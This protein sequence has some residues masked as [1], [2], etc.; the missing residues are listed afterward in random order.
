[1]S[2]SAVSLSA[3]I[4]EAD[5]GDAAAQVELLRRYF[6]G[7]GLP[8]DPGEALAWCRRVALKGS[9]TASFLRRIDYDQVAPEGR[10]DVLAWVRE[11]AR[12]GHEEIVEWFQEQAEAGLSSSLDWLRAA[13]GEDGDPALQFQIGECLCDLVEGKLTVYNEE[14]ELHTANVWLGKAQ[15]Q[16]N[17]E[18]QS[19]LGLMVAKSCQLLI[20]AAERGDRRAQAWLGEAYYRGKYGPHDFPQDFAKSL[21]WLRKSDANGC[22]DCTDLLDEFDYGKVAPQ[23]YPEILDW[24]AQAKQEGHS[25][26]VDWFLDE[27]ECGATSSLDWLRAAAGPG[28]NPEVQ[29]RLAQFWGQH[30]RTHGNA[31]EG[32]SGTERWFRKGAEE[33]HAEAQFRL[34]QVLPK[35]IPDDEDG[36]DNEEVLGWLCKAAGQGY[37]E[38]QYELG[39]YWFLDEKYQTNDRKKDCHYDWNGEGQDVGQATEWFRKAADQG[40]P[41]AQCRLSQILFDQKTIVQENGN[42]DFA[43]LGKCSLKEFC[44]RKHTPGVRPGPFPQ[45]MLKW[46][47]KAAEGGCPQAQVNLGLCHEEADEPALALKW[48]QSAADQGFAGG[49]FHL[50]RCH[51]QGL[52][53]PEDLDKGAELFRRAADQ[54]FARAQVSLGRCCLQ[55]RGVPQDLPGAF[56]WFG[57]AA[58]QGV[59]EARNLRFAPFFYPAP[60]PK[61]LGEVLARFHPAA[62]QGDAAAQSCLG[63]FLYHQAIDEEGYRAAVTWLQKAAEQQEPAALFT[64]GRCHAEGHGLKQDSIQAIECYRKAA[65]LGH[66]QAQFTLGTCYQ[67]GFEVIQD[68]SEAWKW[69]M[70]A[71][72]QMN[73]AA[74]LA[75]R[76]CYLNGWGDHDFDTNRNQWWSSPPKANC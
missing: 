53:I 34:S 1:M 30:A 67:N 40:H 41:E 58:D 59:Y 57:L 21:A 33:G 72:Q 71:A 19:R 13:A 26:V 65:E 6:S 18:A 60:V 63:Q 66:S 48:Y 22:N 39:R 20:A 5:L 38:A 3:L 50:G 55:G 73:P 9:E 27:I 69:F 49:Q 56:G 61:N 70:K 7:S 74:G 44:L 31:P 62:E 43:E 28:G 15:A 17:P 16:G 12:L 29:I 47:G 45:E 51:A 10:E 2:K 64:L 52:G 32:Y 23:G 24:V 76:L 37:A 8:A 14:E 68:F 42:I 46:L 11:A 36:E 35:M 75:L 54:G 4:D 25:R